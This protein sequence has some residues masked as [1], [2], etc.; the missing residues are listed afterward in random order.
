MYQLSLSGNEIVDIPV[1]FLKH[2]KK[3]AVLS[4]DNNIIRSIPSTTFD[5]LDDLNYVNLEKNPCV[6]ATY[7][8]DNIHEMREFLKIHCT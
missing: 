6:S 3:L 4:L 7:N 1:D 5:G 2:N 8:K